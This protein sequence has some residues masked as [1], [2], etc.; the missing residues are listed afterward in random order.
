MS[1]CFNYNEKVIDNNLENKKYKIN[2]YCPTSINSIEF[3]NQHSVKDN[4]LL[5][6][7]KLQRNSGNRIEM[8][9]KCIS[10]LMLY[11]DNL[12]KYFEGKDI[13]MSTKAD[14]NKLN[15][16][17]GILK[18]YDE[19]PDNKLI[20]KYAP[21]YKFYQK[22]LTYTDKKYERGF[23]IFY[24]SD[25]NNNVKV[26]LIDLYHLVIPSKENNSK[27]EYIERMNYNKDIFDCV[28]AKITPNEE[29]AD[30]VLS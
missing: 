27:M 5:F 15:R 4:K 8:L 10:D 13:S 29:D 30:K 14:I 6:T 28:F 19:I 1:F 3:V 26:Y 24:T 18:L 23:Q 9:K 7:N 17:D 16:L 2:K 11:P 12:N 25:I 22:Y 20:I 21:N